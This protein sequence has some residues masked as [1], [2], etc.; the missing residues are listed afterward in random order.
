MSVMQH[1]FVSIVG[2]LSAIVHMP[3]YELRIVV[4]VQLMTITFYIHLLFCCG[5]YSSKMA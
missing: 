4:N 5:S 3:A 2:S 1:V